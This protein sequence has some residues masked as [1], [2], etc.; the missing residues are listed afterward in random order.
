MKTFIKKLTNFSGYILFIT[1]FLPSP[2]SAQDEYI[3]VRI[4]NVE[5]ATGKE[6]TFLKKAPI[7]DGVLDKSL[8]SLPVRDFSIARKWQSNEIINSHFRLAYG[9]NFLYV[10]IESEADH[11]TYRDRAYQFGDGFMLILAKP[12]PNNQAADEYYEIAC[13]AHNNPKLEFPKLFLS[14]INLNRIF[15]EISADSKLEFSEGNGKI[16]FEL[17]I[18]W[19]DIK[20]LNPF[21]GNQIG[22]NLLFTKASD[23]QEAFVRYQVLDEDR[24]PLTKRNYSL[25]KFQKPKASDYPQ[26]YLNFSEGHIT[27][28]D[29]L[30][31]TLTALSPKEYTDKINIEFQRGNNK[32][33][34]TIIKEINYTKGVSESKIS[35]PIDLES[36]ND[37]LLSWNSFGNSASIES[38]SF[39]IMPKFNEM[40]LTEILS[41]AINSI[42]K[43]AI[44]TLQFQIEEMR[45]ALRVLKTY[46]DGKQEYR[47]LINLM[48]LMEMVDKG[49]DP[50]EKKIG[51]IRKAYRSKLDNTL[52]P[53]I[54]YLPDD[55]KKDK[56]YPLYVFLHGSDMDERSIRGS[57]GLIP[58]GFIGLGPLGRGTSNGYTIDNAQIDIAESIN[59]VTEQYSIDDSKIILAGFSMGGYGVFRTNWETPGKYKALVVFSGGPNMGQMF[60]R[61]NPSP[62]FLDEENLTVFKDLSIFIHHGKK[63]LNAPFKTTFELVEKLKKAGADVE[64]IADP[65][66]GHE[67]PSKV[68]RE[69]YFLWIKRVIE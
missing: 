20:P 11:L 46:E 15:L 56:K 54:V 37:Y 67:A 23:G 32:P 69:E 27:S 16:S 50:F 3:D 22:F 41:N 24:V 48:Q 36:G 63:D 14:A 60:S 13:G 28:G 5:N 55:Y 43:S 47:K 42:P 12:K 45:E 40:K 1:L 39:I 4:G 38:Q 19:K 34:K 31:A 52:Q 35:L 8:E 59:A 68:N 53:Y 7:I 66:K 58:E 18:P 44:T 61:G 64:F 29:T 30:H 49:N 17:C 33:V 2:I 65:D 6:V 57:R 26:V 10:Y 25:L 62:N 51:F 9:I 21:I